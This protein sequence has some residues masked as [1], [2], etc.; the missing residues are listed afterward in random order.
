MKVKRIALQYH[1]VKINLELN[2]AKSCYWSGTVSSGVPT[3]TMT[4]V[5]I[6]SLTCSLFVDYVYL[7]TDERR[8][9]AQ[10]SHEYLKFCRFLQILQI[11][12][13]R[14]EKQPKHSKLEIPVFTTKLVASNIQCLDKPQLL[15]A[16]AA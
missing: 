9:F 8:R 14:V 13:I 6:P 10:V 16:V 12:A 15:V 4:G 3:T 7:D 5:T 1:E 2:D 11:N